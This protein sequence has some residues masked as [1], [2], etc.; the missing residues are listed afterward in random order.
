MKP[1]YQGRQGRDRLRC[2]DASVI[3]GRIEEAPAGAGLE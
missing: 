2:T 3:V 1:V